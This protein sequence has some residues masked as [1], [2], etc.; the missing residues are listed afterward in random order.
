MLTEADDRQ[1]LELMALGWEK[2]ADDRETALRSE[3]CSETAAGAY[4]L[5]HGFRRAIG[6]SRDR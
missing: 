6:S 2:T 3:H 4:E 1:A 5:A